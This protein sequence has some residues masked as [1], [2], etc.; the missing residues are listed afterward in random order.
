VNGHPK[1][2]SI[3]SGT[4]Q[5]AVA[6]TFQTPARA[7][8]PQYSLTEGNAPVMA[9]SYRQWEREQQRL[10][11]EAEREQRE[12]ARARAAAEKERQRQHVAARKATADQKTA[13]LARTVE[14]LEGILVTGLRRNYGDQ[15][16]SGCRGR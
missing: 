4:L 7:T 16:R 10:A 9:D 14:E 3:K 6:E 12:E 1:P 5:T 11:R 2:V 13:Q 15:A 8:Y